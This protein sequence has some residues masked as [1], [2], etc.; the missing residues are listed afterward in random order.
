MSFEIPPGKERFFIETK[1][2]VDSLIR[3]NIFDGIKSYHLQAWINNFEDERALYLSAHLLDSLIYR[4]P[5]MLKS[6]RRHM[7]EMQLVSILNESDYPPPV[8][9]QRFFSA[10]SS[11]DRSVP[12]R[13]VA[14]DGQFEKAPAKSGAALIRDMRQD[15]LVHKNLTIRPENVEMIPKHVKWLVLLDDFVGTGSQVRK[16]IAYYDV[17]KWSIGRTI[18]LLSFMAHSDG[19]TNISRDFPFL[20]FSASEVVSEKNG[21]FSVSANNSGAWVKDDYNSVADACG[22]YNDLLTSKGI[23]LPG[24]GYSLDLTV[25]FSRT[26]PNN[27][28]SAYW[29]SQG[30][31]NPLI[32]RG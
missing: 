9:I 24:A 13:F 5:D 25:A 8:T 21:F 28:L 3:K 29:T 14:V 19:V 22:F 16:F 4:S 30:S 12:I 7:L 10:L 17:E 2:K 32:V 31:W 1:S 23:S 27:T 6:M 11:G 15:G 18:V 26:I 20:K